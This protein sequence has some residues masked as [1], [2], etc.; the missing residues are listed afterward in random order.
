M[1]RIVQ[2]HE[3]R[4]HYYFGCECE[5]TSYT[6]DL[7][8]FNES[9]KSCIWFRE[10]LKFLKFNYSWRSWCI[11]FR[12][13][14]NEFLIHDIICNEESSLHLK[15]YTALDKQKVDTYCYFR[16][17]N[18]LAENIENASKLLKKYTLMVTSAEN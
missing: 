12:L 11:H 4:F 2:T 3:P 13:S 6:N 10:F 5:W 14:L 7:H 18:L 9:A 8:T 17:R 1:M 15:V 16:F